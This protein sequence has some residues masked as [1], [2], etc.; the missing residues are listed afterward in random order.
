MIL[1]IDY[2]NNNNFLF[3]SK[4]SKLL[5]T[6]VFLLIFPI[7]DFYLALFTSLVFDYHIVSGTMKIV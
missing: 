7:K 1:D 5:I 4:L 3:L 6:A 2:F